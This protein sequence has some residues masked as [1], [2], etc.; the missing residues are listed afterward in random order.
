MSKLYL[1]NKNTHVMKIRSNFH[2]H[3]DMFPFLFFPVLITIA[4]DMHVAKRNAYMILV[5]KP[6]GKWLC[7]DVNVNANIILK[8]VAKIQ[9]RRVWTEFVHLRM[10][11][12][13]GVL[14]THTHVHTYIHTYYILS[15]LK[16]SV[17]LDIKHV[18]KKNLFMIV[19]ISP[20]TPSIHMYTK[21][22]W[23]NTKNNEQ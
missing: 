15:I 14:G 10:R 11:T 12:H 18:I 3:V 6:T 8:L 22:I 9:D 1:S 16:A 20:Y 13:T 23:F 5:G 4:W 17:A 21:N 2:C 19:I 7:E